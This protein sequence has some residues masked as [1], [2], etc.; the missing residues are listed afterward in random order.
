M[1]LPPQLWILF[2][3]KGFSLNEFHSIHWDWQRN[4]S[5]TVLWQSHLKRYQSIIAHGQK[6]WGADTTDT[7]WYV[8]PFFFILHWFILRN[9]LGSICPSLLI[10]ASSYFHRQASIKHVWHLVL[11][12]MTSWKWNGNLSS[13]YLFRIV[14]MYVS[15]P[16]PGWTMM[17]KIT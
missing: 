3:E 4:L 17:E 2:L 9:C 8:I 13:M 6:A 11:T 12:E 7:K 14:Y 1:P 5:L 15:R 16:R 10:W